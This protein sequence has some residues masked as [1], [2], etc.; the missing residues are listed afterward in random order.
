MSRQIRAGRDR[1]LLQGRA[2]PGVLFSP[3]FT[4]LLI[5][6]ASFG[7]AFSSFFLLPKFLATQLAASPTQIGSLTTVTSLLTVF[8][9]IGSGVAVDRLGRRRLLLLGSL[10]MATSSVAFAAVHEMGLS[11]Y[12]LRSLQALAFSL[13]YVGGATM[14][15]DL[16]PERRMGEALGYF[17]LTGLSMNAIAPAVVEGFAAGSGWGLAF[18]SAGLAALLCTLLS[19]LLAETRRDA[20]TEHRSPRIREILHAPGQRAAIV[21]MTL[22]GASFATMFIYHQLHA[23]ELGITRV[24]SFFIS[25]AIAAMVARIGFG[26]VGDRWGRR[27]A[28]IA[29]LLVYAASVFAMMDVERLGLAAIGATFG[30]AHGVF[31]PTYSALV[32]EGVTTSAR[33]RT[34]AL[35]Q[36]WF[37]VGVAGSALAL[38]AVAEHVGY[39]AVFAIAGG[40]AALA[41]A[42]LLLPTRR[43]T[44]QPVSSRPPV[45]RKLSAL[46]RS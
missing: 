42:V 11:I 13:V 31:Y 45:Q 28:S 37:N 38:G 10:L 19:S 30:L 35:L 15:V 2:E 1:G 41:L 12:V 29:S 14:T 44:A 33:G 39:G 20:A 24:R 3:R 34:V 23:L 9:M 17:G 36:A 32:L 27:G 25:Y 21:V 22:I 16:A 8:F 18:V 4:L 6:Q 7:F 26:S 5:C 43:A 46:R 40:C